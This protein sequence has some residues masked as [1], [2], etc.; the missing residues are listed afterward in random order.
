MD[1]MRGE[2]VAEMREAA[3]K[4]QAEVAERLGISQ[5][6]F[7]QLES[8]GISG[9]DGIKNHVAALGGSLELAVALGD[10]SWK[11]PGLFHREG[12]S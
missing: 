10:R 11:M 4:T 9:L 7:A 8:D 1:Y 6:R 2:Y 5:G 12:K 3:Q